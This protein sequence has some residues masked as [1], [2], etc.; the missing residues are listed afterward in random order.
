MG[1]D[2][3]TCG[4]DGKNLERMLGFYFQ[5]VS[6][7]PHITSCFTECMKNYVYSFLMCLNSKLSMTLKLVTEWPPPSNGIL[8]LQNTS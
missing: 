3:G 7:V 2:T 1:Y 6:L 5:T 8:G 4:L